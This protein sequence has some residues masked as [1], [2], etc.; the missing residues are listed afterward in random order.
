MVDRLSLR[1]DGRSCKATF[2]NIDEDLFDPNTHH[3]FGSPCFVLDSRLQLGISGPPKWEPRTRLGIYVGHSP[4]HAGSVAL[5][6]N[7][8][9]GHVSH[10]FHVV[11]DDLFMT[12][13]YM[14]KNE[15]PPN[16]AEL[17]EKSLERVTDE[18]YN[19]AKT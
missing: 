2:F 9:T 7:S 15:V 16:W 5:V 12:V 14:K 11:F 18:D 19:L 4:S 8:R 17:V 10:Q 6:L 3:I 13:S 1:S